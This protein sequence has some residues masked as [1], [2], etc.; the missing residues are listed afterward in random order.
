MKDYHPDWTWDGLREEVKLDFEAHA[1]YDRTPGDVKPWGILDDVCKSYWLMRARSVMNPALKASELKESKTAGEALHAMEAQESGF[2]NWDVY[3]R[4]TR[5]IYEKRA[6][7]VIDWHKARTRTPGQILERK[8]FAAL[9][10][11]EN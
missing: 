2:N 9:A 8:A 4:S 7:A 1:I 11:G 6:Q 3:T 10:K 5:E